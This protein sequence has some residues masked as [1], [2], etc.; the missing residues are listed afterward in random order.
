MI[1]LAAGHR[2]FARKAF[3][4]DELAKGIASLYSVADERNKSA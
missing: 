4:F 3:D 1:L 2:T